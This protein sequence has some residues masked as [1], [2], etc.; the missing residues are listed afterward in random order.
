MHRKT[1]HLNFAKIVILLPDTSSLL[2][3]G[4]PFTE[5]PEVD[6][7]NNYAMAQIQN[8]TATHGAVWFAHYQTQGKGR[9]GKEWKAETGANIMLSTALETSSLLLSEQFYLSAAIALGVYHFF[10]FYAGDETGIKW[11]N[12]IYWRDRKTAGILIE[13]NIRG[14]NWQWAVAGMGININ[15]TNFPVS[16]IN[17]V[18]LKQIT[19]KNYDAVLLAKELCNYLDKDWRQLVSNKEEIL[20][21]YNEVLYKR[22]QQVQ[23]KKDNVII[24]CTIDKV[25]AFGRLH[26]KGA[27]HESFEFGEVQWV[28]Q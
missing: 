23:L 7:S 24:T 27:A 28:I 17:P 12:D 19:G 21:Q 4:K 25:D 11:P 10:A 18:S 6:S 5:L 20:H 8:G 2:T 9:M 26:V 1:A 14:N 15:Q 22:N 13:N 16:L 3:I